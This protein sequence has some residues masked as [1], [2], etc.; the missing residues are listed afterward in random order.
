VTTFAIQLVAYSN[1]YLRTYR[2]L[3]AQS[4]GMCYAPLQHFPFPH[5]MIKKQ[6]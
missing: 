1:P 2:S 6:H 5:P 4:H 3:T